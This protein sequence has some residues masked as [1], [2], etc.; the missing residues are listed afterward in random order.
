MKV[1]RQRVDTWKKRIAIDGL[2]GATYFCQKAQDNITVNAS[3]DHKE[4][5]EKVLGA[6]NSDWDKL[7]SYSAWEHVT[8][9]DLVEVLYALGEAEAKLVSA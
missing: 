7:P 4:I 6:P 5:C 2:K 9:Y 1:S 3:A 8:S